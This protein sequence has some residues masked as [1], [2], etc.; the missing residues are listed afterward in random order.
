MKRR[1]CTNRGGQRTRPG[2]FGE[3]P[4]TSWAR[5]FHVLEYWI[6]CPHQ[7]EKNWTSQAEDELLTVDRRLLLLR[8]TSGSSSVYSRAAAPA[9]PCTSQR[10]AAASNQ[11]RS[12]ST[13]RGETR[14]E[15]R[16]REQEG[17]CRGRAQGAGET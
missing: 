11:S 10:T 12:M 4:L 16:V 14:G 2:V 15:Q 7:E 6:Q 3:I 13:V 17:L 9:H 5:V 8:I 1:N